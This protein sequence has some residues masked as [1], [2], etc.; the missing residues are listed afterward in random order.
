MEI[1]FVFII[2][3]Y[4]EKTLLDTYECIDS[5]EFNIESKDNYRIIIIENGSKD[6]SLIRLKERYMNNKLIDIVSSSENLGF[7]KGNNLGCRK[8]IEL[9]HP[10]F[11]IVINNDTIIKQSDF[12]EIIEERYRINKFHM[13]GPAIY[14]RH[15][16]NQNPIGSLITDIREIEEKIISSQKSLE[17]LEKIKKSRYLQ[18]KNYIK[19]KIYSQVFMK[20]KSKND[21]YLKNEIKNVGLHGAAIIFSKDYYKM[22]N[23]IF[24]PGTFLYLEEDI[25]RYRVLNDKLISL[26]YPKAEIFHKEDKSTNAINN[27][28][29]DQY[30]FKEKNIIKSLQTYKN[31]ILQDNKK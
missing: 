22:Y 4:N 5:I 2:L 30:I 1:K 3:H 25:L 9:Y 6:N 8:A 26:Y 24:F 10:D 12:L 17:R 21:F 18:I 31:L 19:S 7:A 13:L 27:K 20:K 28:K 11:L 23:D 16:E 14:D 29:I 15:G